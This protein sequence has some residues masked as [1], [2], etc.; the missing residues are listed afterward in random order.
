MAFK[1]TLTFNG[2]AVDETKLRDVLERRFNARDIGIIRHLAAYPA[3]VVAPV[4]GT[5][6]HQNRLLQI[7]SDGKPHRRQSLM[8]ELKGLR[9]WEVNNALAALVE[10]GLSRRFAH[11]IYGSL[12][13]EQ[14]DVDNLPERINKGAKATT[15]SKVLALIKRGPAT[16]VR[17]KDEF[18]VTR[19]RVEQILSKMELRGQIQRIETVGERGQYVY[20]IKGSKLSEIAKRAPDLTDSRNSLLS[21]LAADQLFLASDVADFLGTTSVTLISDRLAELETW[22]FLFTFRV[23]VKVFCGLTPKGLQHLGYNLASPKTQAVDFVAAIGKHKCRYLQA[24]NALGGT[25]KTIDLTYALDLPGDRSLSGQMIQRLTHSRLVEPADRP[26]DGKQRAHRLSRI[27]T[28]VATLA[29]RYL[30]RLSADD[31]RQNI[32]MRAADRA[33]KLGQSTPEGDPVL[34]PTLRSILATLQ[35][36]GDLLTMEVA[37]RM[38]VQFTNLRSINLAM[39][40][41]AGRGLV[42]VV[43]VERYRAKRWHLTGAGAARLQD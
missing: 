43:A 12:S 36:D 3:A 22:G 41:L 42:E 28:L 20:A 32:K 8:E 24:L 6:S 11:G 31:L 21:C 38:D 5:T 14:S 30:P 16:A 13:V 15:Y 37:T 4:R 19:Q 27:G 40:T 2:K 29:D 39:K 35:R 33:A 25:A 10:A 34:V 7:L 1:Y 17:I 26:V 9:D 23:G 18:G